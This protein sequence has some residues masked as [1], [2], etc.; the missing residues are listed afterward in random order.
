M[1]FGIGGLVMMLFVL[2][3]AV[4]GIYFIAGGISSTPYVDSSGNTT[5]T[6]ANTSQVQMGNVT[7]VAPTIGTGIIGILAVLFITTVVGVVWTAS[8]G[9][10]GYTRSRYH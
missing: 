6:A 3:C 5:T 1:N 8:K 10:S 7:G 4:V 9:G 2:I